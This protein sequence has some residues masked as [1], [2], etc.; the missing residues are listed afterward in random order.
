MKLLIEDSVIAAGLMLASGAAV[1]MSIGWQCLAGF[2]SGVA[3][4]LV[5]GAII[6]SAE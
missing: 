1:A 6:S 5:G 2:V 4:A 3:A